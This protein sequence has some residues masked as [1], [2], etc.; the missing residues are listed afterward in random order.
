MKRLLLAFALLAS[1]LAAQTIVPQPPI[2]TCGLTPASVDQVCVGLVNT[3]GFTQPVAVT[4]TNTLQGTAAASAVEAA[5]ITTI[6]NNEQADI[7]NLQGQISAIAAGTGPQGPVGPAGPQGAAGPAGPQGATGLTG[8][9]GPA[10][11]IGP[12]GPQGATGAAGP[13]GP[14]G[15]AGAIGAQGVAGAVGPA[16]P[17][18]PAGAQGPPGNATPRSSS[19]GYTIHAQASYPIGSSVAP[20]IVTSSGADN[21]LKLVLG[22]AGFYDYQVNVPQAGNYVLSV[23]VSSSAPSATPL[24]LHFEIPAGTPVG[25]SLSFSGNSGTWVVLTTP[26]VALQPGEQVIRLV[27]DQAGAQTFYVNWIGLTQQ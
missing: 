11:A 27:E 19:S 8:P 14:V 13:Q 20:N 5:I 3:L 6:S 18:G 22:A 9:A 23:R 12:A 10:G 24:L 2:T 26:A 16:G 1:P 15:P 4:L 7:K 17:Q 25:G 21:G